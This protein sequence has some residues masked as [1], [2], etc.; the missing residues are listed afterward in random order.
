MHMAKAVTQVISFLTATMPTKK[1]L[2]QESVSD[3]LIQSI[4]IIQSECLQDMIL[5]K[6][7]K[8]GHRTVTQQQMHF[9][10]VEPNGKNSVL[11]LMEL[12]HLMG[13]VL[14]RR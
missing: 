1:V 5:I 10:A 4:K 9:S 6:N 2:T 7:A 3:G 13:F 14:C 12:Y 8:S 11:Q